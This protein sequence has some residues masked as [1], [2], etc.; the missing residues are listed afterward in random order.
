MKGI[1]YTGSSNL[2]SGVRTF[3]REFVSPESELLQPETTRGADTAPIPAS[4]IFSR[5]FLLV[6]IGVGLVS[7]TGRVST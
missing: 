6:E 5:N 7:I 1:A 2:L 4:P 3:I